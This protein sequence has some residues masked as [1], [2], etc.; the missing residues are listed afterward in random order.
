M[1]LGAKNQ[2]FYTRCPEFMMQTS[3]DASWPWSSKINHRYRL[4]GVYGSVGSPQD[5]NAGGWSVLRT[6]WTERP[7]EGPGQGQQHEHR[8]GGRGTRGM[9]GGEE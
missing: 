6:G 7:P 3:A 2:R 1:R 5:G 8:C 4:Q 9:G